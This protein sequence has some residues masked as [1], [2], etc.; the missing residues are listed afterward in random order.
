MQG[1]THVPFPR[2]SLLEHRID[3][4]TS[5]DHRLGVPPMDAFPLVFFLPFIAAPLAPFLVRAPG[6][7]WVLPLILLLDFGLLASLGPTITAGDVITGALAWAPSLKLSL[8]WRLDGLSL[9][10]ALLIAG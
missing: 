7:V 9:A 5:L 10:F 6:G 1:G 3:A 4:L 2:R 8:S